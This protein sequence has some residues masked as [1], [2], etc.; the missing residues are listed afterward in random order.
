MMTNKKRKNKKT[1]K[2]MYRKKKR[3]CL[4]RMA[5]LDNATKEGLNFH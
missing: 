2:N 4:Q 3:Q 1:H 5:K